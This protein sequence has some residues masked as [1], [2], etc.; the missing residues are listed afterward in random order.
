MTQ[1]IFK[2]NDG[3]TRKVSQA[4]ARLLQRMRRGAIAVP[5]AADESAGA[6]SA[7]GSPEA[8]TS[9]GNTE[10]PAAS[11]AGAS[12][13]GSA[14]PAV[15]LEAMDVDALRALAKDRGVKVHYNAGADKIREALRQA[16]A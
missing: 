13:T 5:D 6:P 12:A 14:P 2:F 8:G 3:R 15:D 4:E 16:Q 11:D 10:K 7:D 9:K 1:V